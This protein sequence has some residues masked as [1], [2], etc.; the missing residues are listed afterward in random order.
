MFGH[1]H[2]EVVERWRAVGAEILTTGQ[3]GT[4]TVTTDGKEVRVTKF[5]EE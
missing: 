5:L 1:P 3:S 4:I 2:A